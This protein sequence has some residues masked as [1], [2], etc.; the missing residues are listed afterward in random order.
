MCSGQVGSWHAVYI[1]FKVAVSRGRMRAMV[2]V[3]AM[4]KVR[5]RCALRKIR[6]IA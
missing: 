5:C 1:D 3:R 2:R 6:D 4:V